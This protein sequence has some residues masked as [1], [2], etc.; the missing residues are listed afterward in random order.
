[1]FNLVQ[2]LMQGVGSAAQGASSGGGLGQLLKSLQDAYAGICEAV[3]CCCQ[4]GNCGPNCGGG[5]AP[6]CAG[7]CD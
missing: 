6:C 4:G 7:T 3:K 1:M 5:A 2:S